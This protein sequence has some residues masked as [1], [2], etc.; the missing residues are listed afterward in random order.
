MTIYW[1]MFL[2]PVFFG[3]SIARVDSDIEKIQWFLYGAILI[4]IIGLRYKVGGDWENYIFNYSPLDGVFFKEA[5]LN[6]SDRVDY[7][8]ELLYWFF[9]NTP[10]GIYG[11]NLASAIIFV[12]GLLRFCKSMPIPWLALAI[13]TPYLVIVVSTGYTR[14]GIT[15]GLFMWALVDLKD[16]KSAKFYLIIII[17]SLFHK[18]ILLMALVGIFHS[19]KSFSFYR[20]AG[21]IFIAS[22]TILI[23]L[24]D[25]AENIYYYYF[26]N[27]YF[28]SSGAQIRVFMNVLAGIIFF[29]FKKK[30]AL[31]YSD[32]RLWTIIALI[33]FL[34]FPASFWVST[35]SD[36]IA[37]YLI[38]IQI[39]VYS[40]VPLL[41][42]NIR[43]RTFMV[44]C[45]LSLY[46][47]SLFVWTNFGR[48][49]VAWIPYRNILFE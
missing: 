22:V 2:V 12:A 35:F 15:I 7:G 30:W 3:F 44:I 48:H 40:K 37:L 45:V 1:L 49:S 5:F 21:F 39:A 20:L 38:P 17:G 24:I 36:R 32:A 23:I 46:A 43:T 27:Q 13:A 34:L 4:I 33:N 25:R 41:I 26:E 8:F 10:L 14:Q 31:V 47:S 18:S 11:V 19:T 16:G 42:S 6:N 29:Y 28:S 9:I